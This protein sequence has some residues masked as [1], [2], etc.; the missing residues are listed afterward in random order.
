VKPLQLKRDGL[1]LI[2]RLV[3]EAATAKTDE[4]EVGPF[5]TMMS[6]RKQT[7]STPEP[8]SASYRFKTS[9]LSIKFW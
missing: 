7:G 2:L 8:L 9:I 6:D 5:R 3:T 1:R 4:R